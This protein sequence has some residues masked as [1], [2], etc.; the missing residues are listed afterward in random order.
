M[1]NINILIDSQRRASAPHGAYTIADNNDHVI[2]FDIDDDAG[3]TRGTKTAVFVTDGRGKLPSVDFVGATVTLPRLLP[4]DGLTLYVGITQGEIKTTTPAIIRIDRSVYGYADGRVAPDPYDPPNYDELPE[5]TQAA[6]ADLVVL[7]DVSEGKRVKA[8]LEVIKAAMGAGDSHSPFIGQN[9]HWYEYDDTEGDYVDTQINAQGP[10]GATGAQGP[11]GETGATGPQG[12]KGETGATGPQGPKGETGSQGPQGD[13][14]SFTVTYDVTTWAQ[15]TAA[16]AAGKTIDFTDGA[17]SYG[18]M[19]VYHNE[20]GVGFAQFSVV[21]CEDYSTGWV[22]LDSSLGWGELVGGELVSPKSVVITSKYTKPDG[23]IPKSDLASGVQT[24]LGKADTALQAASLNPYRTAS[25]QDVIDAAQNTAIASKVET[26][27]VTVTGEGSGYWNTDRTMAQLAAAYSA[28]KQLKAKLPITLNND[29]I[30]VE[31]PLVPLL[32]SGTPSVYMARFAMALGNHLYVFAF[33]QGGDNQAD[34]TT[35]DMSSDSTPAALGTAS[36]G[37]SIKYARADHVHA[38][39]SASDIGA[40][41]PYYTTTL[42]IA[43]TDWSNNSY[44]ANIADMTA[45]ALVFVEF[46]DTAGEYT[47]T[48]GAETLTITATAAPSAAITVKVGWFV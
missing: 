19:D 27:L 24:S 16:V 17:G 45:T 38:M 5:A 25:D 3:F 31:A 40:Q 48:Q 1:D 47:V 21:H 23:G 44:T 12:P 41:T 14:G 33:M 13:S 46:S 37:T 35:Q 10:Q 26:Y 15:L 2:T 30:T 29:T 6:L 36:A 9:G 4:E 11:Q 7:Y 32:S 39:P 22:E 20:N 8:S 42:N 43:T 34:I 18:K 28:G